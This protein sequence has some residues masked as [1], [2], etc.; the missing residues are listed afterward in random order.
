[1][2]FIIRTILFEVISANSPNFVIHVSTEAAFVQFL[3][4][5]LF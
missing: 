5:Y 3:D 1:L 4:L 2:H